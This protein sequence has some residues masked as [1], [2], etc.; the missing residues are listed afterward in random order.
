M[1][2]KDTD[3]T[4]NEESYLGCQKILGS[5]GFRSGSTKLLKSVRTFIDDDF[6]ETYKIRSNAYSYLLFEIW[7]T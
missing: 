7:S 5:Y 3:P 2:G 1:M 6:F 4:N